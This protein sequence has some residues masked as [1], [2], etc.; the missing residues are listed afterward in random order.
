MQTLKE[1]ANLPLLVRHT[2]YM[3][4]SYLTSAAIATDNR[5]TIPLLP[6]NKDSINPLLICYNYNYLSIQNRQNHTPMICF[7]RFLWRYTFCGTNWI[8]TN[9]LL[10]NMFV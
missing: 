4:G 8:A 3:T 6:L 7:S 10:F 2:K 1:E 9:Y 5:Y